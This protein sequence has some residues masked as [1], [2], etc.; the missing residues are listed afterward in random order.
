[1]WKTTEVIDHTV[2]EIND[3]FGSESCNGYANY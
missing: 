1:M 3:A 2:A